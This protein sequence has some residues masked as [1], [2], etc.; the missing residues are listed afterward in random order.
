MTGITQAAPLC[1]A[2]SYLLQ[3]QFTNL[4]CFL[5]SYLPAFVSRI[6]MANTRTMFTKRI[7]LSW[8]GRRDGKKF[9]I[10][11]LWTKWAVWMTCKRR[12]KTFPLHWKFLQFLQLTAHRTLRSYQTWNSSII[13]IAVIWQL[14][15]E[16]CF[17]DVAKAACG[18]CV[19]MPRSP[20]PCSSIWLMSSHVCNS[21]NSHPGLHPN[22]R[23][24]YPHFVITFALPFAIVTGISD[25]LC[26][27]IANYTECSQHNCRKKAT[28]W[29]LSDSGR[30]KTRTLQ[31]ESKL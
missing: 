10:H 23:R 31:S 19:P 7:K 28:W 17:W 16:M 5:V 9:I 3:L 4:Y 12:A 6:F 27:K 11:E 8:R 21:K 15:R 24:S 22:T 25:L 14:S 18:A 29:S 30:R 2:C 20:L 26:M 1:Q 13:F